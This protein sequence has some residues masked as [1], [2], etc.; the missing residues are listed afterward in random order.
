MYLTSVAGAPSGTPTSY[1]GR[2]ALVF[3]TT[4]NK[5]CNYDGSWLCSGALTDYAEWAPAEGAEIAD[6]VSVTDEPNTIDD[7]D[8]P[9]MLGKSNTPYDSKIVGVVS[10]YAEKVQVANGYKKAEHYRA[11]ALAGR[12]PVKVSTESGSIRKGDFLTSSS[13]PGVAMKATR[14]GF[15]IGKALEDFTCVI[16]SEAKQSQTG[17]ATDSSSPRNDVIA[18]PTLRRGKQSCQGKI[19]AFIQP[20][21]ADPSNILANLSLDSDGSLIVPTFKEKDLEIASIESRINDME[22]RMDLKLKEQAASITAILNTASDSAQLNLAP[23]SFSLSEATF[24]GMLAAYDL[25]VSNIFKSLGETFL[26]KTTIA[27]DLSVDGTLSISKGNTID[28]IG[29]LFLQSSPLADLI[30]I[31]NGKVIIDKQG[32]LTAQKVISEKF[33]AGTSTLGTETLKAGQTEVSINT[34]AVT[35]KSNIFTSL[36]SESD[37]PLFVDSQIPSQG[38]KVKISKPSDKDIVFSWWIVDAEPSRSIVDQ[39]P[40]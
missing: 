19:L 10:E 29:T 39:E 28:T 26:G 1:T 38:F 18:I 9:F 15:V 24:S 32:A 8:D 11:I 2:N 40:E 25:S 7:P 33:V 22:R 27:G 35:N 5:L 31:F 34:Q 17:I 12:V 23:P 37:L 4:N 16:A 36:K 20:S 3:D 13:T 14:P 6:L 30:N 21:Y